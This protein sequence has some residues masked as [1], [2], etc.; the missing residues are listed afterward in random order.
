M[1]G[2][3]VATA[4]SLVLANVLTACLVARRLGLWPYSVL[5]AKP[6]AAGLLASAVIVGLRI[7]LPL[8]GF[9]ALL[10]YAPV[11]LAVF[12]GALVAL[13]LSASDR[14]FIDAFFAALWAQVKGFRARLG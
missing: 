6:I 11:F 10:A 7:L 9:P 13:G 3:A 4:A 1:I 8:T 5:H 14:G 2:A 12:V